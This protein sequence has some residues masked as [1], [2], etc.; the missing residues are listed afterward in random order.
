MTASNVLA[1][2]LGQS[3]SRF[4]QGELLITSDRGKVAGEN[5]LPALRAVFESTQKFSADVLAL[6]CTGFYGVVSEPEKYLQLCKDF[7][8]ASEVAVIDDG[9]AGFIGALN[10]RNGVVLS[11]GGGVVSIGGMDGNYAHRDGLGN[12]FGDE[13]G[14]FWLGKLAITKALALRQGR[15]DDPEMVDYFADEI[16]Q[17]FALEI[18]NSVDA[19]NLATRTAKKVLDAADAGVSTATAIV[20]EGAFLLAQSVVAAWYGCGG[21]K[22]DSPEIVIQGGPARNST[23]ATKIALE[24]NAKL[25]NAV[26][27]QSSGDNLDG[28]TWIA[29]NMRQDAPPLLL[30]AGL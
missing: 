12:T 22:N 5:P 7:F 27:V 13:G 2:D 19:V 3:G 30:W 17:Y 11:V 10:G 4:K 15:G 24:V 8:G 1:V 25:P 29:Q 6:S 20:D 23:Y 21:A 28:A 14:G 26:V 9:L 18:R 16:A